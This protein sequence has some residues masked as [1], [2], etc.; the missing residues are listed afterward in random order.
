MV[1]GRR[2]HKFCEFT[3][4]S[5][6]GL[7][8]FVGELF[9]RL[10]TDFAIFPNDDVP[11]SLDDARSTYIPVSFSEMESHSLLERDILSDATLNR[12]DEL[13][14]FRRYSRENVAGEAL[15]VIASSS[16]MCLCP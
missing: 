1:D 5:V 6:K 3:R 11:C 8:D 13:G 2:G 12:A 10:K 16:S 14:A 7:E 15:R 4:G 9:I